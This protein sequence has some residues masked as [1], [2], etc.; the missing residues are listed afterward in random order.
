MAAAEAQ[1]LWPPD[2]PHGSI[3]NRI[4]PGGAEHMVEMIATVEPAHSDHL[5]R[6]TDHERSD[7]AE[8][9]AEH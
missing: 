1:A 5:R 4:N 2:Q 9:P 7:E 8:Q 3:E 6:H